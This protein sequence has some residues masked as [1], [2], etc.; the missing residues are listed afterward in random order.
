M[1]KKQR[2]VIWIGIA[3]VAISGIAQIEDSRFEPSRLLF[4]WMMV[5]IVGGGLIFLFNKTEEVNAPSQK[6]SKKPQSYKTIEEAK[7]ASRKIREERESLDRGDLIADKNRFKNYKILGVIA[8]ESE[9]PSQQ[10]IELEPIEPFIKKGDRFGIVAGY[11]ISVLGGFLGFFIGLYYFTS[12]QKDE[13][14]NKIHTYDKQTRR[15]GIAMMVIGFLMPA[16]WKAAAL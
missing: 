11:L 5:G 6:L 12:K 4:T 7:E 16:I 13:F 15:H 14:G 2:A 1:N 10:T 8:E 3:L 9:Q